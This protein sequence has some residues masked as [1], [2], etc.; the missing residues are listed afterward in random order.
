M[1]FYCYKCYYYSLIIKIKSVY[2]TC[3]LLI[4]FAGLIRIKIIKIIFNKYT[5]TKLFFT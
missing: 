2:Q 4:T 1:D 5:S 3:S